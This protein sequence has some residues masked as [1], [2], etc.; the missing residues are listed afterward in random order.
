[1]SPRVAHVKWK[2]P[3]YNT[4][5]HI[6]TNPIYAGAYAFGRSGSQVTIEAGRKKLVRGFR[7]ERRDWELLIKDHHEG[8]ITWAEFERN[9]RL[10]IDNANGKSFMS[11]GSVRCGEALL[12]G[13]LRCGH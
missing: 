9:Q 4:T 8:F 10:M 5:Y 13:L 6:L 3:V 2:L 12:A 11:R 7:R 1:M